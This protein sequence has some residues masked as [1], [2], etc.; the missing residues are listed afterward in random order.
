MEVTDNSKNGKPLIGYEVSVRI[1]T[2]YYEGY[3]L[4]L[5]TY[6]LIVI[7]IWTDCFQ[8]FKSDIWQQKNYT[9]WEFDKA[10]HELPFLHIKFIY[11]GTRYV[12]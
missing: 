3:L 8:E 1:N 9:S 7:R 10:I 2:W 11:E 12:Q 4:H 5:A 6:F